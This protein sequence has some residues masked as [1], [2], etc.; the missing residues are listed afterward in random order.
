MLFKMST[1]PLYK[2]EKKFEIVV[3]KDKADDWTDAFKDIGVYQ[4]FN[5]KWITVPLVGFSFF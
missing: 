1:R 3:S 5:D 4:G 2:N